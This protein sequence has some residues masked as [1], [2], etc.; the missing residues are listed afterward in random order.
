MVRYRVNKNSPLR[1]EGSKFV[2]I[3]FMQNEVILIPEDQEIWLPIPSWEG[4]YEASTLGRIR[5]V[6]RTVWRGGGS[7]GIPRLK[8]RILSTSKGEKGYLQVKLSKDG[9]S[10]TR[11]VNRLV[12]F[13]F[14]PNPFNL[15]EVNHLDGDKLNNRPPNLEWSTHRNNI[16]HAEKLGLIR[17][18]NNENHQLS[19]IV[20]QYTLSMD[21]VKI[22]PSVNQTRRE[23]WN[24]SKIAACCRGE[25]P[26]HKGFIWKYI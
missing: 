13:A 17:H 23:G 24:F 9:K 21:L 26:Q 20:Y 3:I 14:I 11:R 1:K 4:F 2:K 18:P 19:K 7:K 12:A 5:S 10:W 25:R 22:W 8:S 15:P 16:L 6:E